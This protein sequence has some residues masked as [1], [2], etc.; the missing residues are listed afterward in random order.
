L[1]GD[2][3]SAVTQS[4]HQSQR[5]VYS[6]TLRPL[7][8][9]RLQPPRDSRY[10]LVHH[11]PR[12]VHL[13]PQDASKGPTSFLSLPPLAENSLPI[14]YS[15]CST[16]TVPFTIHR[17][18]FAPELRSASSGKFPMRLRRKAQ[19]CCPQTPPQRTHPRSQFWAFRRSAY[20]ASLLK[21]QTCLAIQRKRCLHI[22]PPHNP[23]MRIARHRAVSTC[24]APSQQLAQRPSR[25]CSCADINPIKHPNRAASRNSES[26]LHCCSWPFAKLAGHPPRNPGREKYTPPLIP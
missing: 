11:R 6:V 26:R 4:R 16:Y 24:A 1:F 19:L 17:R 23:H 13:Q 3:S 10:N 8:A 25:T 7:N 18:G 5:V 12:L 14:S 2:D 15:P 20:S 21:S 9:V 22:A